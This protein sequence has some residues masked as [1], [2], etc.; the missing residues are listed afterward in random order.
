MYEPRSRSFPPASARGRAIA[1][2]RRAGLQR[3]VH[4]DRGARA[5][6]ARR[7]RPAATRPRGPGPRPSCCPASSGWRS[8]V[9]ITGAIALV[10][11]GRDRDRDGR[12]P[13]AV[14]AESDRLAR[15]HRPAR[16]PMCDRGAGAHGRAR[17]D[18][19]GAA[20]GRTPPASSIEPA[21]RARAPGRGRRAGRA[22]C[23]RRQ[24][25][26]GLFPHHLPADR[27]S[28]FRYHV[29]CFA[30]QAYAVQALARYAARSGDRERSP[31]PHGAPTGSSPCRASGVSGGGTTTGGT[32]GSSSA[33][34]CTAST[35][36]PWRRWRCSSSAR[37]AAPTTAPRS[38]RGLTL[39][40]G[41]AASRAPSSS[42][43]T[44]GV[45]WRKV[46]RR[47]PRKMVRKAPRRPR[48]RPPR[49]GGSAGWTGCSRPGRSTG[50]AVPFELGWLLYAWH[51]DAPLARGGADPDPAGLHFWWAP[52][53]AGEWA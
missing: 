18:A 27:L 35:S 1:A 45:V 6:P 30:D 17:L 23:W 28:R 40:A 25:A 44:D 8:P 36:T 50:S 39:A 15:A 7:S 14:L 20:A 9:G 10:R 42:S 33:T 41:T 2:D 3:A 19:G 13:D 46:G 48:R 43:T 29:S 24:G 22:A 4:G 49:R 51:A 26:T 52:A 53:A 21:R 34:R 11:L 32:A 5:L 37:P 16:E 12:R 47:E 31:P 38:P